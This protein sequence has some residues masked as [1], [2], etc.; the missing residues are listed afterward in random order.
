[1]IG[2]TVVHW[3][4]LEGGWR[5]FKEGEREKGDEG[6]QGVRPDVLHKGSGGGGFSH[7]REVYFD[8]DPEYEGRF[9]VP[10]LYDVKT[11]RIVNNEVGSCLFLFLFLFPFSFSLACSPVSP[12]RVSCLVHFFSRAFVSETNKTTSEG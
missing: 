8:V 6:D 5:F 3:E 7:L 9:T 12:F 10:V 2:C 11:G 1:M 4:M